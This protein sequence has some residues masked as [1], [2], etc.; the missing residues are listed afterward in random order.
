VSGPAD[1]IAVAICDAFFTASELRTRWPTA[2]S[3]Q[4]ATFDACAAAALT[5]ARA[6]AKSGGNMEQALAAAVSDAFWQGRQPL[7]WMTWSGGAPTVRE[8]FLIMARAA[9]EAGRRIRQ[10]R[11]TNSVRGNENILRTSEPGAMSF[12][13]ERE[14]QSP[15]A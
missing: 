6:A 1:A 7:K 13:H 9:I 12:G 2:T 14:R 5:A 15:A 3:E 4:R 8:I 10:A 11:A